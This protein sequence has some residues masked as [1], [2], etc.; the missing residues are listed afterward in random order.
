MLSLP[1]P[2]P[3]STILEQLFSLKIFKAFFAGKLG[4]K[5]NISGLFEKLVSQC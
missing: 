1:R 4:S 2:A 3:N 5:P